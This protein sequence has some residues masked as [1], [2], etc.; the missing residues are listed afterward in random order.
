MIFAYVKFFAYLV[1][2]KRLIVVI[3]Q[4]FD[5]IVNYIIGVFAGYADIYSTKARIYKNGKTCVEE[6]INAIMQNILI[7]TL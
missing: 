4:I 2:S 1:K 3:L 7:L 6:N 5:G